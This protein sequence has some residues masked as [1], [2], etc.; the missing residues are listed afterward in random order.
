MINARNIR[1][2]RREVIGYCKLYT[3]E[4]QTD[5]H[6]GQV[7]VELNDRHPTARRHVY[8]AD[9]D[10]II[11]GDTVKPDAPARVALMYFRNSFTHEL[12]DGATNMPHEFL[13]GY[14]VT[15]RSLVS[16][17]EL[18]LPLVIARPIDPDMDGGPATH[19]H[20]LHRV[21]K[22]SEVSKDYIRQRHPD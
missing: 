12:I 13:K 18:A 17:L 21:N 20:L 11:A 3:Y 2:W 10:D 22:S 7:T 6:S 14:R 15:V 8:D 4:T 5:T 19:V 1:S 9:Q 16:C